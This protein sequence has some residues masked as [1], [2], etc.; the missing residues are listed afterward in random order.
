MDAWSKSGIRQ[1]NIYL[2]GD[3]ITEDKSYPF[4]YNFVFTSKDAGEKE[5]T[6]KA[7]DKEGRTAEDGIKLIIYGG[8]S[9]SN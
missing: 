7:Y 1:V 5:F 9:A 2:D 6:I 8:E 4:G 3:K